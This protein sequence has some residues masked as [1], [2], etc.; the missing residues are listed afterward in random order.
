MKLCLRCKFWDKEK[1]LRGFWACN[2]RL[3]EMNDLSC[4]VRRANVGIDA[5][6]GL[7]QRYSE[8]NKRLIERYEKFMNKCDREMDEG[9]DWKK[10]TGV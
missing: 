9:D 8:G 7:W 10:D 4:I 3:E 6:Y 2:C 1:M 5:L